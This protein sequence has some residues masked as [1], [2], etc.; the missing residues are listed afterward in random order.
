MNNA[1]A[2]ILILFVLAS[3]ITDNAI[4][5]KKS[6]YQKAHQKN[7]KRKYKGTLNSNLQ[8]FRLFKKKYRSKNI[9]VAVKGKK[10]KSLPLAEFDPADSPPPQPSQKPQPVVQT[11]EEKEDFH[12]K[13]F[14]EQTLEEKHVIEDEILEEN[15]LP[16]PTSEKHDE[17]RKLVEQKLRNH[18]DG[19]PIQLEP[20]YFTFDE[21]EFSVVDM[22]P[23]LVAVE[24]ALQ[25][26]V[27]L[28]EGHTDSQGVDNY[29]VR[30]SIQRVEKIRQLM[31]DMG[32]P[33]E[34]ISVVGYGEEIAEHTNETEDGRQK[35]R[36]VDFTVF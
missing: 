20:L 13:S 28:I 25:G 12:N 36:R 1:K 26:R 10:P 9:R 15:N 32:V 17:I 33:D 4:A 19:D 3:Y 27:V 14:D 18:K 8:C 11:V 16:A 31:Q 34:R 24:Y 35:N 22:E 21:D 23:F 30:L 6:K 29:N 5:Q 7:R 2:F